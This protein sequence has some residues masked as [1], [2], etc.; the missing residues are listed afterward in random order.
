MTQKEF[1]K[2]EEPASELIANAEQ[3]LGGGRFP[4]SLTAGSVTISEED[5]RAARFLLSEAR[6]RVAAA[7]QDTRNLVLALEKAEEAMIWATGAD[8]FSP[9]GL[10]REGYVNLFK[11]ALDT[12]TAALSKLAPAPSRETASHSG[13][14]LGAIP[15]EESRQ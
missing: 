9:M 8:E 7:E 2:S 12:V 11:P 6:A 5:L 13:A 10:A 15:Q 4:A 1:P 14:A 3:I